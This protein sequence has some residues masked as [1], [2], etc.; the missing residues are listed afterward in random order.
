LGQL[1]AEYSQQGPQGTGGTLFLTSDHLGS[2][3][4]VTDQGK[5]IKG[6][7]DYLPFGEEIPASLGRSAIAGYGGTGGLRHKFTA[8]ERD[9]ESNLD[10]FLARYH[11]GAQGRF[12]SPDPSNLSVDFWLPQTWNRYSYVLNNPLTMVDRNGLWPWYIHEKVID[13]AFP[14]LSSQQLRALKDAN[15]NMHYKS[16]TLGHGPQDPAVAYTHM[17]SDGTD[18]DPAH[19][20]DLSM[21]LADKFIEGNLADAR[22]AQAAWIASGHSG[23]SPQALAVFGNALHTVTDGTSPAHRGFQRWR[24]PWA[25]L[26]ISSIVHYSREWWPTK[27]ERR[28]AVEAA[29]QTFLDAFGLMELMYATDRLRPRV[30]VTIKPCGGEG[31]PPDGR[32]LKIP[33]GG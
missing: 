7:H 23:I 29:R 11:S 1:V 30:D 32:Q 22:A 3:R 2:T 16:Q 28:S 24:G 20:L 4:V 5:A 15:W 13:E 26:G 12:T 27:A 9:T 21:K 25:Y 19:G 18:P 6:R 14:G 31:Q 33:A 8:K 10:Y 17:M